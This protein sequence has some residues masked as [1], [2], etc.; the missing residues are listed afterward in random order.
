MLYEFKSRRTGSV[1]MTQSVAEELLKIIGKTPGP[2][3]II[4]VAQ[5]PAAIAAMRQAVSHA[6]PVPDDADNPDG[7]TDPNAYVSLAQRT[8][9]LIEL[10]EEAHGK[11][12]DITWGV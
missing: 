8:W 12:I 5:M 3:G 4:T 11:N 2:T 7:K 10:L 9:P 6:P 1:T